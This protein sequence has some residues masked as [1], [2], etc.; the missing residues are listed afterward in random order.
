MFEMVNPP[1]LVQELHKEQVKTFQFPIKPLRAL[2]VLVMPFSQYEAHRAKIHVF[3]T[4]FATNP[5]LDSFP[6]E[7]NPD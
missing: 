7:F 3:I 4:S 6:E 2:R 1:R 5:V